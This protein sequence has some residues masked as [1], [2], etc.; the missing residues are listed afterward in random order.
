MSIK[1]RKNNLQRSNLGYQTH[2]LSVEIPYICTLDCL[3]DLRHTVGLTSTV[4][5]SSNGKN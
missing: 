2:S 5:S 1:F 3:T 4:L